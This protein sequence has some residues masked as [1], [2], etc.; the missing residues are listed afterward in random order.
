[1]PSYTVLLDVEHGGLY[2]FNIL[3][4]PRKSSISC[5]SLKWRK[6]FQFQFPRI[7]STERLEI[8]NSVSGW[9]RNISKYDRGNRHD[10]TRCDRICF[11]EAVKRGEPQREIEFVLFR[12]SIFSRVDID[13]RYLYSCSRCWFFCP[14][15]NCFYW[16]CFLP[17]ANSF[18]YCVN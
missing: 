2:R 4:S 18:F 8:E 16:D 17:I 14:T 11:I 3:V 1:M 6:V 15:Q 5:G 10:V 12:K 7:H 9:Y 13:F